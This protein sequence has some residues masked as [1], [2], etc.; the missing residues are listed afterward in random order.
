MKGC[1]DALQANYPAVARL[2]GDEWFRAAAAVYVRE[3]AAA[4]TRR[5]CTTARRFADFLARF[6]PAAELP[7]LPGVARLDRFWTE[8]HAAAD[9]AALDPAASPALAPEALA[10]TVLRPHPAARWAWFADAP[11]LHA[12]GAQPRAR[13]DARRRL[14]LAA[15]KAR[16]SRGRDDAVRWRALD[17]G[18]CAF[19]DACAA[20]RAPLAAAAGAALAAAARRRPGAAAGHAARRRRVRRAELASATST[21]QERR[22][23]QSPAT[24]IAPA[25]RLEPRRRPADPASSATPARAGAPL[26]DRRDL[27]PVRPHQGRRLSDRHRTAYTLFRDEYKLPLLPPEIAAHLAAYAEHLFPLLL[28]LGLVTRLSALALLGMTAVIQVFVYPDAW[29]T[30]L[31]W[32]ALLLYLVGRGAGPFSL[33]RALGLK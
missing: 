12:S 8:A 20:R 28:V 25:R 5:C 27:L 30:H 6:A 7:Y 15:A 10:R 21:R 2:V 9:A 33:D 13:D 22:S 3:A 4:P 24:A 1:I 19:L 11:D 17:A 16:C 29:P 26:R 14:A 32:A 31:S 23:C 18:G